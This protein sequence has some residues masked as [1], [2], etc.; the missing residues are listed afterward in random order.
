MSILILLLKVQY[1]C[2]LVL[3]GKGY[4]T[5]CGLHN[6]PFPFFSTG[7]FIAI[8]F[9]FLYAVVEPRRTIPCV[10]CAV[11]DFHGFF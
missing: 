4:L 8:L 1:W 3:N 5:G 6:N 2:I 11:E 9:V 7:L 10:T